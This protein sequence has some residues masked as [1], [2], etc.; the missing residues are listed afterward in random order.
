MARVLWLGDVMDQVQNASSDAVFE[1]TNPAGSSPIVVVCEHASAYMPPALNNLGLSGDVLTS[2]AAWDPGALGV[3]TGLSQ[4]LDAALVASRISRL[5]YD[6]NRPP[7]HPGAMPARSEVFDI[8]G[9]VDLSAAQ[10]ETRHDAYYLPFRNAVAQTLEAAKSPI[11]VT[12]HS[13][14]PIYHGQ[15]REVEIG[16]LHDADTRLVD[17]MLSCA[18]AH[19]DHVVRRNEPYGPQDGV[20]HTVAEHATPKGHPNVMLE[21]RN[22]L[23]ATPAAQDRMAAQIAGWLTQAIAGATWTA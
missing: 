2:H 11:L 17:A 10:R 5:V 20:T 4:R 22:D 13:F 6:C 15:Q 8:P 18:A 3:A 14:T 23:I 21:V 9:N 7:G 12:M 19:T 1:V 16:L